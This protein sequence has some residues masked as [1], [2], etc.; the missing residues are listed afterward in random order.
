MFLLRRQRQPSAVADA[1]AY[2]E[3]YD[4]GTNTIIPKDSRYEV[5]VPILSLLIMLRD[6]Q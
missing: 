3:A 1:I 2:A 5:S 6:F 4:D